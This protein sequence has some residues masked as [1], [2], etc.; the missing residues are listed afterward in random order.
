MRRKNITYKFLVDAKSHPQTI[1]VIKTRAKHIDVNIIVRHVTW[2]ACII[3]SLCITSDHATWDLTDKDVFGVFFQQINTE[4]Q[5]QDFSS[6]VKTAH[7][8]KV[9][10]VW[11]RRA[12]GSA[13]NFNLVSIIYISRLAC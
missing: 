2:C 12:P 4:G 3:C 7:D 9:C 11:H 5:L 8:N 1:E 10:V 6:L 13:S